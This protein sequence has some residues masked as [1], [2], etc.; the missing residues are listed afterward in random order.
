[1]SMISVTL[2]SMRCAWRSTSRKCPA[3]STRG[4]QAEQ[5]PVHRKIA[6]VF[7]DMQIFFEFFANLRT[8]TTSPPSYG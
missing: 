7:P 8:K 1:M 2:G 5:E 6:A 4:V 3:R